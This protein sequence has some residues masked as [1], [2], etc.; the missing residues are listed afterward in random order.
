MYKQW[1][2]VVLTQSYPRVNTGLRVKAT[3]LTRVLGLTPVLG[4]RCDPQLEVSQWVNNGPRKFHGCGRPY[5]PTCLVGERWT[6]IVYY[7]IIK[8]QCSGDFPGL[9]TFP[10]ITVETSSLVFA[11]NG[12][13]GVHAL[14]VLYYKVIWAQICQAIKKR[15]Q[16]VTTFRVHGHFFR[17]APR[18]RGR[19]NR[20]LFNKFKWQAGFQV[21]FINAQGS[22]S[23]LNTL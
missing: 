19:F 4:Y 16:V 12:K 18:S 3:G 21:T 23:P 11:C 22:R 10:P 20:S 9:A 15:F 8:W 14:H 7:K 13:D 5:F 6:Q 17:P 1:C 2:W